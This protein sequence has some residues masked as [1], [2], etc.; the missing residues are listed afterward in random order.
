METGTPLYQMIMHNVIHKL[1]PCFVNEICS[2]ISSLSLLKQNIFLTE[3]ATIKLGDF[4]SACILN[5]HSK[6]LCYYEVCDYI[7]D[8]TVF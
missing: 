6:T 7:S 2:N 1:I 8:V 5:R 4:G 3:E